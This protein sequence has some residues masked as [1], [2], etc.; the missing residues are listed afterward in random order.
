MRLRL[1]LKQMKPDQLIPINYQHALHSFIYHTISRS[2]SRY[3]EW[4]HD[5]GLMSGNKK[6]KY[7]TFSKLDIRDASVKNLHGR[8]YLN[9]KSVNIGLTVSMLSDKTTEHFII[10]MFEEQKVKIFDKNTESEFQIKTVEMVPEPVFRNDMTFRTIS[11]VVLSR[12]TTYNGNESQ[13]YMSPADKEYED[14]FIKNLAEKHSAL[15]QLKEGNS[16]ESN[17]CREA[18]IRTFEQRGEYKSKL[19]TIKEGSPEENKIRGYFYTFSITGDPE[20]IRTG[21]EAGFGK[22]C[23]LGFGCAEVVR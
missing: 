18:G 11:P 10:G 15:Y 17:I 14:Y 7:F 19:I 3:S 5:N 1:V 23:S 12:K 4:L 21:Y 13:E 2:D 20:I 9:I 8:M 16:G 6:F 22:Q